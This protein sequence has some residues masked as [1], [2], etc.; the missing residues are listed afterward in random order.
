MWDHLLEHVY[1]LG[2]CISEATA[3]QKGMGL[4]ELILIFMLG[5]L[6]A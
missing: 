6:L 4:Y 5:L 3:L 2:V 1:L